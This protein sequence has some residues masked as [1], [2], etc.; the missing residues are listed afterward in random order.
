MRFTSNWKTWLAGRSAGQAANGVP[1]VGAL[2]VIATGF[3]IGKPIVAMVGVVAIVVVVLQAVRRQRAQRRVL[4]QV[5]SIVPVADVPVVSR[6]HH[7]DMTD[8][9]ILVEEMLSHGRYAL[10][11]RP[12]IVGN[13]TTRQVD[14]TRAALADS[15]AIVP[16]GEVV[17]SDSLDIHDEGKFTDDEVDRNRFARVTVE[18][19]LLDRYLVTNRQYYQFVASGGYEQMSLWE[20]AILAAVLDFVDETGA[21]GPRFWRDG[22]Y[23]SREEDFPVVGICWYEAAAFARW[24][25]KRLP[26]DA[27]WVKAASWPVPVAPGVWQQRK[28]PWGNAMERSRANLWGTGPARTV[29]IDQFSEGVSVGGI[30][31]LV[32][33]VWEWTTGD[34]GYDDFDGP[35]L[36]EPGGSAAMKSL[37][38]GAFDTYF[39]SQATCHFRSGD[40]PLA[41]KHNVGFRCALSACDVFVTSPSQDSSHEDRLETESSDLISPSNISEPQLQEVGA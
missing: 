12:Q 6:A 24:I 27:E 40:H 30:H 8:L 15:M 29:P 5:S 35:L 22:R 28:F 10:L 9:G 31:Q 21:P 14:L 36:N 23:P 2:L 34:F 1:F 3:Y 37:R 7:S 26:S 32:G 19:F 4:S 33:N 20:P 25:G 38:G 13:L 18:D 16:M 11:L 41:R 17:L 39:E